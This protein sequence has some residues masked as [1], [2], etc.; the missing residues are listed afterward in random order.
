VRREI[1]WQSADNR[2]DDSQNNGADQACQKITRRAGVFRMIS[3]P[4]AF[5]AGY[6]FCS[7]RHPHVKN[8]EAELFPGCCA[9]TP[10]PSPT[11]YWY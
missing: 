6:G 7:M 8:Q 10:L 11:F 9:T 3:P 5:S 4:R 2:Q 1:T